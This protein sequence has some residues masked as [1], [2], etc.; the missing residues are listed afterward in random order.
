MSFEPI[1]SSHGQ[2]RV[3]CTCDDCSREEVVRAAHGKS[4]CDGL[5][6]AAKKVQNMGW[7]FIGKRLRCPKCEAK[8]KVAKMV[9]RKPVPQESNDTPRQPTRA[10]NRDIMDLLV[11]VYDVNQ[12]RYRQGDTDE[13]VAD[14]L[15]VMPGWVARLREEFFGPAGGNEEM[16]ALAEQLTN[17]VE[18]AEAVRSD[19]AKRLAELDRVVQQAKDY[20]KRLGAIETAVG[21]RLMAQVK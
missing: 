15:N 5:G 11:E 13:T 17:F 1:Q 18:N 21:P 10:Q 12:E 16:A 7:T 3:R 4:G 2:P 19:A 14:V 20:Q 9:D 8:R 6:Q